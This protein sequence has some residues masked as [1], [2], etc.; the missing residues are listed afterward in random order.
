MPFS[1]FKAFLRKAA[2]RT[3]SGLCRRIRSFRRN[4]SAREALNHFWHAGYAYK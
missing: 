2:E 1:K 3:V 4:L